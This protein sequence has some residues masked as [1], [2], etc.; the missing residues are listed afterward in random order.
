MAEFESVSSLLGEELQEASKSFAVGMKLRRQ[1]KEDGP[2]IPTETA[3][4]LEDE[5]DRVFA[6]FK[7]L[8]MGDEARGFP[9]ED[10]IRRHSGSPFLDRLLR[11]QAIETVID[12]GGRKAGRV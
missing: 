9:R 10:E 8:E 5:F 6:V 4:A 12:L 11:R 2:G 7:P 1:L 3:H